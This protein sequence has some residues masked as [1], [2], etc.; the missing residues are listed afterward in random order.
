MTMTMMIVP[1]MMRA[2]AINGNVG[3][4]DDDGCSAIDCLYHEHVADAN[5]KRLMI[6]MMMETMTNPTM[7]MV[8]ILMSE[9]G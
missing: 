9:K 6:N 5:S 7:T 4:N 8:M 1:I 2:M 3:N